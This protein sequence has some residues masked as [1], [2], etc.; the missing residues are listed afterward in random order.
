VKNI[1]SIAAIVLLIAMVV[2]IGANHVLALEETYVVG[3]NKISI[4][5]R[6]QNEK[7]YYSEG[8]SLK[9]AVGGARG[10]RIAP[11]IAPKT[12]S[13]K[14]PSRSANV[15]NGNVGNVKPPSVVSGGSAGNMVQKPYSNYAYRPS[16]LK[17]PDNYVGRFDSSLPS[18]HSF[19]GPIPMWYYPFLFHNSGSYSRN[20][21]LAANR[22]NNSVEKR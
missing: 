14:V 12:V 20:N 3:E 13:P 6:H 17:P 19:F 22:S 8:I 11:R 1:R 16:P 7:P 9:G 21:N 5:S 15:K 10:I 2:G 4:D 18:T